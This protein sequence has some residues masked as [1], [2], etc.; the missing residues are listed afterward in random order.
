MGIPFAPFFGDK[1]KEELNK[2]LAEVDKGI[3][4]LVAQRAEI[5]KAI[6]AHDG[7]TEG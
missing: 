7:S 2:A 5:V 6:E 4:D 3:A 1:T